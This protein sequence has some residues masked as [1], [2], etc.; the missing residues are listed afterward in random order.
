MGGGG[1][2]ERG[3]RRREKVRERQK[4]REREG[5]GG[6][7]RGRWKR[8]E[9]IREDDSPNAA[10]V[11]VTQAESRAPIILTNQE[12]HCFVCADTPHAPLV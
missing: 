3:E 10:Q 8:L 5:G 12:P 4:E 7:R 6:L 1:D 11:H 2:Q 9:R